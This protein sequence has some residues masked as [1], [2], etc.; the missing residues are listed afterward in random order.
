M[1]KKKVGILLIVLSVVIVGF[2]M[3]QWVSPEKESKKSQEKNIED[4]N[5]KNENWDG[6]SVD[7]DY[8]VNENLE[9][10]LNDEVLERIGG[11]TSV[12][13]EKLQLYLI[14]EHDIGNIETLKWDGLVLLDYN[15]NLIE[16]S[17]KVK[18]QDNC[19]VKCIY[20]NQSGEWS[21]YKY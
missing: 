10:K 15:N 11:T 1:K 16:L 14:S 4:T 21:F 13:T 19:I 2:Y 12:L 8:T 17:F 3:Y 7:S 9:C 5:Q 18:G 6:D 20:A